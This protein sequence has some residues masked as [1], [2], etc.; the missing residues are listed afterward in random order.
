MDK[1]ETENEKAVNLVNI[2]T[3]ESEIDST[4]QEDEI[5]IYFWLSISLFAVF[6]LSCFI[7]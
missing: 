7:L 4:E 6:V 5:N 3:A 1:E 2:N